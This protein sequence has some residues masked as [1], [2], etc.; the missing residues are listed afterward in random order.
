MYFGM[1][2]FLLADFLSSGC[3][4]LLFIQFFRK[5]GEC[6]FITKITNPVVFFSRKLIAILKDYVDKANEKTEHEMLF[7]AVKSLEYI[8]KFI[9]RSRVLFAM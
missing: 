6:K 5:D 9:I 4:Y 3:I 1:Q 7:R 2:I 8:F